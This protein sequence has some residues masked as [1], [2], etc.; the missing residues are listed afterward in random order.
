MISVPRSA[1]SFDAIE[2]ASQPLH[3]MLEAGDHYLTVTAGTPIRF[4]IVYPDG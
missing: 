2:Q 1:L 3:A 4:V